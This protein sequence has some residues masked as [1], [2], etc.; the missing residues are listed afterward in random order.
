MIRVM[1]KGGNS[2]GLLEGKK[3]KL[4]VIERRLGLR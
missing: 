1:M 4:K 3:T 2:V